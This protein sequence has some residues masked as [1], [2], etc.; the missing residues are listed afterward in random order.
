MT[1]PIHTIH[2][3]DF[4]AVIFKSGGTHAVSVTKLYQHGP[5]EREYVKSRF[6]A[7]EIPVVNRLYEEAFAWILEEESPE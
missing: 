3:G 5:D 4:K 1:D 2:V 7:S 6:L